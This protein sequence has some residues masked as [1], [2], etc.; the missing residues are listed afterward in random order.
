MDQPFP[1]DLDPGVDLIG[2]VAQHGRP[3]LAEMGIAG[4]D[5]PVPQP[6][7]GGIQ[8]QR[9]PFLAGRQTLGELPCAP[10]HQRQ[11]Q[12]HDDRHHQQRRQERAQEIAPR[13]RRH[14]NSACR[15]ACQR[16]GQRRG[17]GAGAALEAACGGRMAALRICVAR[18]SFT[19]NSSSIARRITRTPGRHR[20]DD[21]LGPASGVK[22]EAAAIWMPSSNLINPVEGTGS[23]GFEAIACS[24]SA[25]SSGSAAMAAI[26]Q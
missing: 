5:V 13:R 1:H 22:R 10:Q 7:A 9:Q 24:N 21:L 23:S 12:A 2:R 16:S 11:Q 19:R 15:S 14:P 20:C 4:G 17:D 6:V 8:C 26:R 3:A 18:L 25:F